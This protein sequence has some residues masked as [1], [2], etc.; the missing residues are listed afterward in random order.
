MKTFEVTK[1]PATGTV[2]V[3]LIAEDGTLVI[4]E[5]L[6][7]G[8]AAQRSYMLDLQAELDAVGLGSEP[9]PVSRRVY[10]GPE[11]PPPGHTLEEG[12]LAEVVQ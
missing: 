2:H 6:P 12:K 4:H 1:P 11:W 9:I 5:E 3:A 10:A 7:A 8:E